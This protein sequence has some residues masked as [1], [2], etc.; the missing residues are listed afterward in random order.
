LR[1]DIIVLDL[2]MPE[3]DGW[4]LL[5]LLSNQPDTAHIPIMIC[6]VLK[7]KQ[8]ALSLGAA[9]FLEKPFTEQALLEML[10]KLREGN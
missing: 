5:Q 4:D 3:Q 6:S 9:A 10:E 2:M 8:L 1:P 7:Q